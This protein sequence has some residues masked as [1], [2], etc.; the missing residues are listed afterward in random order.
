MADR[1]KLPEAT[2]IRAQYRR[3]FRRRGRPDSSLPRQN[4]RRTATYNRVEV[5]MLKNGRVRVAAALVLFAG[6]GLLAAQGQQQD[7]PEGPTFKAQVEY[8]EVDAV[9]TDQQGNFVRN[10]KKEDFQVSE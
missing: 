8:V 10:L 7:V 9:V 3:G 4:D 5:Q 1:S 6:A 2:L